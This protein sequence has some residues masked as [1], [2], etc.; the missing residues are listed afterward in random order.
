MD[1]IDILIGIALSIPIGILAGFSTIYAFN[2]IPAKWLCDYG[3]EPDKG[4]WDER[5]KKHPWTTVF[6][7]VFIA[8]SIKLIDQ[9]ILYAVAGMLALWLLLQIGISDKMF[10]IIPDQYVIALAVTAF[11]FIPFHD[12]YLSPLYGALLGG[13]CILFMGLIGQLIFKREAMGFGD[14]KLFAAIGLM[15]GAKGV[16]II[17][18]MTIFMSAFIFGIGILTRIMKRTDMQPFGPFIAGSTAVY[19]IFNF[20]IN[21]LVNIYIELF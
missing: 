18:F 10:M 7:L 19:L 4:M 5:I 16:L 13:G 17:L 1:T 21:T 2:R 3:V 12:S 15:C 8:S 14:V 11:G 9:G 20:E 6:T